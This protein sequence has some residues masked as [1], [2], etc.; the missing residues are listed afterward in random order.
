M[1]QRQVLAKAVQAITFLFAAF[2]GFLKSIEPPEGGST[3]FARGLASFLALIAFLFISGVSRHK[4]P[5]I[6]RLIW[7]RAA[8]GLA[9][10]CVFS[11]LAYKY[12]LDRLTFPY[13][14]DNAETTLIGGNVPMP[15]AKPYFDDGLSASQVLAKFGGPENKQLVWTE[16]SIRQASML[17]TILYLTLIVSLAGAVFSLAEILLS[18]PAVRHERA[19]TSGTPG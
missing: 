7:L 6:H 18:D 3:S 16:Q 14:P 12:E 2:G 11:G 8:L 19:Q 5:R 15:K 13:P 1:K 4:A 9:L 10:V 17:L